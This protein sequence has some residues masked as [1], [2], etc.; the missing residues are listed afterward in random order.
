MA[1]RFVVALSAIKRRA[2]ARRASLAPGLCARSRRGSRW[3]PWA[4]WRDRAGPGG[5]RP[6]PQ[7]GAVR[8]PCSSRSRRA[9]ARRRWRRRW[10][11]RRGLRRCRRRG[12]DLVHQALDGLFVAVAG[13][14]AVEA[15]EVFPRLGLSWSSRAGKFPGQFLDPVEQHQGRRYGLAG[16]LGVRFEFDPAYPGRGRVP[17]A[18]RSGRPR[19]RGRHLASRVRRARSA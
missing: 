6:F 11:W 17:A 7:S 16:P 8:G 2:R 1:A 12:G 9:D 15:Q 4:D 3:R 19:R 18:G 13:E 5:D 10:P 14:H